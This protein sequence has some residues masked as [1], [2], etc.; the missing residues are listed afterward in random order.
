MAAL[1]NFGP[2]FQLAFVTFMLRDSRF[3]ASVADSVQ[4]TYFTDDNLQRVVRFVLGFY[5]ENQSAPGTLIYNEIDRY[6]SDGQLSLESAAVVEECLNILFEQELINKDYLLS[7]FTDFIRASRIEAALPQFVELVHNKDFEAAETMMKKVLAGPLKPTE[8]ATDYE[9]DPYNRIRRRVTH[10]DEL[11]LMIPELDQIVRVRRGVVC[12]VQSRLSSDGKTT[13]LVFVCRSAL[14]QGKKVLVVTMEEPVEAYEDRLDQCLCNVD[15]SQL[16]DYDALRNG[17]YR[18]TERGSLKI[19]SLPPGKGKISDIRKIMDNL[20]TTQGWVPD[21]LVLDYADRCAPESNM[22]RTNMHL[23]G[24]EVFNELDTL[25]RDKNIFCWTA[26]QSG[27]EA[28]GD[29]VIADQGHTAGSI[30][31]QRICRVV[32]SINRTVTQA[33]ENKATLAIVKNTYGVARCF[34]EINQRY[35][36]MQFCIPSDGDVAAWVSDETDTQDSIKKLPPPGPP[37]GPP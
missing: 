12:A 18:Y 25:S 24:E 16:R 11:A 32:I 14:Y 17:V 20:E 3:L 5:A 6:K 7:Q 29:N 36:H 10:E 8:T 34:V 13:F 22:L 1:T 2:H 9:G 33:Q 21:L 30:S 35:S 31:K 37:P 23:A 15:R 26:M 27:R 19:T 4:P 28:G